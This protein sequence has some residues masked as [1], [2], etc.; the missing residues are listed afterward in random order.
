VLRSVNVRILESGS[1]K[2]PPAD[3][4]EPDWQDRPKHGFPT[5][6]ANGMHCDGQVSLSDFNATPRREHLAVWVW[7]KVSA[8]HPLCLVPSASDYGCRAQDVPAERAALRVLKGS[9]VAFQEHWEAML[10]L[11]ADQLP[12]MHGPRWED[13]GEPDARPF[14]AMEPTPMVAWRGQCTV[15]TQAALHTAWHNY[16]TE[17]RCGFAI[18][19][20]ALESS[21]GGMSFRWHHQDDEDGGR[22]EGIRQRSIELRPQLPEHRRHLMFTEEELDKSIISWEEKW[23]PVLRQRFRL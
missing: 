17:P 11:P 14:A 8:S 5:Q 21:I 20:T 22:I 13:P 9:H 19:W 16:D 23:P 7:L 2:R 18:S 4:P 10:H 1:N 12:L 6:W 3:A 15:W